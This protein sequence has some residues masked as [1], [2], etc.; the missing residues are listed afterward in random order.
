[1]STVH[2]PDYFIEEVTIALKERLKQLKTI[3]RKNA[4]NESSKG[5]FKRVS[6]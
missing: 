2:S 3:A 5:K 1:M 4:S 6:Q